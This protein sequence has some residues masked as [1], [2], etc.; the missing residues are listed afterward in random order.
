MT[1]PPR[2]A[3]NLP[4]GRWAYY[5]PE[6]QPRPG[7]RDGLFADGVPMHRLVPL[8]DPKGNWYV[9]DHLAEQITAT[10]QPSAKTLHYDLKDRT[11]LSQRYPEQL[12]VEEWSERSEEDEEYYK[13]YTRVTED[14]PPVEYVYEGPYMP[15]VGREPPHYNA[16]PPWRGELPHELT[17]YPEY[18]HLF[19]GH[20][21]GLR[22]A[23]A[24]RLKE[25][26]RAQYVFVD[27]DGFPG[28]YVSLRVPFDEPRTRFV[29]DTGR[30]GRPKKSGRTVQT[31]VDRR[32]QLPVP[33]AVY[34]PNYETALAEWETQIAFWVDQV[35]QA[36]VAACSAC[37][38][39]GFVPHGALEH[40]AKP[41]T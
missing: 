14:L 25:M 22:K 13:L 20:I 4:D 35:T 5:L 37:G 32:L 19:P 31:L 26:V 41:K 23:V 18:R 28:V 36:S 1:T 33:S 30:N 16:E 15:L 21:P 6:P 2:Y 27:Y 12:S 7:L 39:H 3:L 8:V 38:G 40:Q 17:Q 9:A 10:Y 11:A 29:A 34:G 24:E